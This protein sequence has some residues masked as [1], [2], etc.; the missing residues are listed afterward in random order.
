MVATFRTK[1]FN[2]IWI[3]QLNWLAKLNLAGPFTGNIIVK[4]CCNQKMLK[5]TESE[6]TKGFLS[7]FYHWWH[8]L[9]L[10]SY[11][12]KTGFW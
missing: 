2:F 7:H 5:E 12:F 9:V 6:E 8:P 11:G 10:K 1:T 3:I 4:Y